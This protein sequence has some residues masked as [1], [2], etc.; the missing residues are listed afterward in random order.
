MSNTD[1]NETFIILTYPV[2]LLYVFDLE[3]IAKTST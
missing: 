2:S 3:T 1:D